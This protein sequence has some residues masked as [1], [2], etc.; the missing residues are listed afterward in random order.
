MQPVVQASDRDGIRVLLIDNPPVNALSHDVRSGLM[1]ALGAAESDPAVAAVVI[2]CAGR[3]FVAGADIRELGTG[4]QPPLLTD[5]VGA[6]DA[7]RKPVVAAL[8]GTTLGGGLELALGCHYRVAARK[9]RLGF[10]EV[11][12]GVIP[13]GRGTQLLPRAVGA[14]KALSMIVTGA[15]VGAEEALKDGLV[16]ALTDDDPAEAAI[17]FAR[18]AAARPPRHLCDEEAKLEADRADRKRFDEAAAALTRRARGLKAPHACVEA[19]RNALDLS[20]EEG[21]ARE[22]AIFAEL[23]SG[24]QAKAQRYAFF[25]ER[26]VGKVEGLPKEKP[27]PVERVA[28]IGAGTMG[29]GIA[30]AFA[31]AGIPVTLIETGEEPLAQGLEVIETTYNGQAKQGRIS[32]REAVRRRGLVTGAVGLHAAAGSDLVVEAVF[33]DSGLKRLIL[34]ELAEL[35]PAD[36]VLATNTSY[37]DVD[38]LAESTG[39]AGQVLGMHF[40]S[41]ANVMRLVEVVRGRATRPEVLARTLSAA[42]RIGKVPV[43]VGVCH[44]FVGN[45]MLRQRN[46]AAE[47]ALLDGA[48]PQDID[49]AMLGFGFP[50]GPLAATDLA[51]LDIGWRMRKAEGL[52][53]EIA[54]ALAEK[55]RFGQKTGKGFYRYE[56][57][58]RAPLP[59]PEVE[60]L[61]LAASRRLGVTRRP[62]PEAEIVER[63]LLP[64]VNEGA[65]VL[66]EGIAARPGDVD[67]IW[68]NGYAWPVWRGGPMYWADGLGLA[69][70]RDRL[71]ALADATGDATLAPAPLITRLAA[72]GKGFA[73]LG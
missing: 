3:T 12:L 53:A 41:P 46:V 14:V 33:E 37:L 68:V 69:H 49:A 55:G 35:M 56:P 51:G 24:E 73:S 19:V 9:T 18:D 45:R 47:R 50:M 38:A 30:I 11:K 70:V 71:I 54:D 57:G 43:V 27:R 4:R 36:A 16:D 22:R 15:P 48:L 29:R 61:I 13:G 64:L 52:R 7:M 62:I 65:R 58:S 5:L 25:A 40:F 63:L 42:R 34:G 8:F 20:Y 67:V 21:V 59:D 72:E 39:R 60:A 44:G 1:E 28:V 23:V 32:A 10:P 66:E 31:D 17:A 6:L 2:A 26:A